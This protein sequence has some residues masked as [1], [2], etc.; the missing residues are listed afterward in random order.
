[1]SAILLGLKH[2]ERI[3]LE[4]NESTNKKEDNKEQIIEGKNKTYVIS[5]TLGKGT[6]GKVKLAYNINNK[7]E[8]YACKILLKSNIKDE[9]DYIRCKREME[10]LKRM[11]H[12]N[13]V[14]TYE[15]ISND[16][17]YYIFMDFCAKGELF[18]YIVDQQHLSE[19]K[20]AFFYYQIINGIEYIHNKG[21]CH[22]D[23]KPENLLL[24][25][26]MKLKIIDFGLSNFFSGNLLET[27]CG[28]PCYASP[29]MVM[30]KK[31]N[32][33]CIDIWSSGIILYAMLCGYLPFEEVEN[34][35]YNEVLFKNI[36]ECNVEYPSEFITPVAKDLLKR[37]LV[38]DPKKRITIDEI[39]QHNF[40]LLGELLYK[41][42]FEGPMGLKDYE[43]FFIDDKKDYF[44]KN[45]YFEEFKNNENDENINKENKNSNSVFKNNED[46]NKSTK[47]DKNKTTN[48]NN[49]GEHISKDIELNSEKSIKENIKNN[50]SKDKENHDQNNKNSIII[51]ETINNESKEDKNINNKCIKSENNENTGDSLSKKIPKISKND[52]K[53]SNKNKKK[54]NNKLKISY[55]SNKSKTKDKKEDK[56]SPQREKINILKVSSEELKKLSNK[57]LKE[58]SSP[59][60]NNA[61]LLTYDNQKIYDN[62]IENLL[63]IKNDQN[64]LDEKASKKYASKDNHNINFNNKK[65]TEINFHTHYLNTEVYP[66]NNKPKNKRDYY[67]Y[68]IL[69]KKSL[70]DNKITFNNILKSLQ[71]KYN[72]KSKTPNRYTIKKK[73]TVKKNILSDSISKTKTK[74]C[75]Q[76]PGIKKF[77]KINNDIHLKIEKN[78]HFPR[79]TNLPLTTHNNNNKN[80]NAFYLLNNNILKYFNSNF[81]TKNQNF[82]PNKKFSDKDNNNN[83]NLINKKKQKQLDN[84]YIFNEKNYV[85]TISNGI[86][87]EKE[88]SK[89]A[90]NKALNFKSFE[91][92]LS[93]NTSKKKHLIVEEKP[94]NNNNNNNNNNKNIYYNNFNKNKNQKIQ[95]SKKS[96]GNLKVENT[97]LANTKSENAKPVLINSHHIRTNTEILN[98]NKIKN[99]SKNKVNL[100]TKKQVKVNS[101]M[102]KN[103]YHNLIS[104]NQLKYMNNI[105]KD[106]DNNIIINLNILKPNIFLDQQKSSKKA[107]INKTNNN[108]VS[109]RMERPM[110]ESNYCSTMRNNNFYNSVNKNKYKNYKNIDT[111]P[112]KK[113]KEI[114]KIFKSIHKIKGNYNT[115]N[116]KRINTEIYQMK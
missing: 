56:K 110:T 59:N 35:E 54:D 12:V 79:Q 83:I 62:S 21:V 98:N 29:E 44:D 107:K 37:I 7:N 106:N 100:S 32:G 9:D 33:F 28:S 78:F 84:Y 115:N 71:N 36:V 103:E 48:K 39:K 25:E 86:N 85:K 77:G 58:L 116:N 51:K 19:E 50:N 11:H 67:Q 26:K 63:N 69:N 93:S 109:S 94:V 42:T 13:V 53:N 2:Q 73:V 99:P 57:E 4:E 14:R 80:K 6:F 52:S 113:S 45:S 75:S 91:Y 88:L 76:S 23:L 112:I 34:D 92:C 47:E 41:Q 111:N 89:N 114:N 60:N 104:H 1:M 65:S 22:R 31:Y 87:I 24:T 20:S 81:N 66:T 108:V 64:R 95:I 16:A 8:K 3:S 30:G 10:I 105:D 61:Q 74:Y 18:N 96:L 97:Y 72:F 40:Y 38:K 101:K 102:K 55:N 68:K 82:K 90:I 15:I 46:K 70:K 43:L 49:N 5:K 27:P 17:V